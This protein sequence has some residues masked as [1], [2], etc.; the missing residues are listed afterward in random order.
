MKTLILLLT[1]LVTMK[2]TVA[3]APT[4]TVAPALDQMPVQTKKRKY[5]GPPKGSDAAKVRMEKVRAAQWVKHGLVP[6]SNNQA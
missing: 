3:E 2:P 6:E 4:V 1:F 5:T